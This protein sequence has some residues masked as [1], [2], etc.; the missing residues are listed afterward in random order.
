M[1]KETKQT[2]TPVKTEDKSFPICWEWPLEVKHLP[3]IF[4]AFFDYEFGEDARQ[5]AFSNSMKRKV[6]W[7]RAQYIINALNQIV[8]VWHWNIEGRTETECPQWKTA[9]ISIFFGDLQLWNWKNTSEGVSYFEVIAKVTAT[10]GS[11]NLDKWE[12]IKGAQTNFFKKACSLLSLG[13]RAYELSMDEDFEAMEHAPKEAVHVPA[14]QE[15]RPNTPVAPK[16]QQPEGTPNTAAPAP[17]AETTKQKI[18]K[19]AG[20]LYWA[21]AI[22]ENV[23]KWEETMKKKFADFTEWEGRTIIKKL[24]DRITTKLKEESEKAA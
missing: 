12:A 1:A 4:S 11:R 5:S 7:Y 19:L 21:E 10:G 9:F 16:P 18:F 6:E 17:M 13:R 24:E 22:P 3:A 2:E 14:A 15:I 8:G 20:Q 23:T